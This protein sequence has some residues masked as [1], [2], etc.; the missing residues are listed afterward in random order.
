MDFT[1]ETALIYLLQGHK[2][3]WDGWNYNEYIHVNNQGKL[4]DEKGQDYNAFDLVHCRDSDDSF[5]I[6]KQGV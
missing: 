1:L 5:V 2:I 6:V 4:V 3:A